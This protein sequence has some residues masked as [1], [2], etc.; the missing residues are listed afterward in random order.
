MG[1]GKIHFTLYN[2]F[3]YE[4]VILMK[5]I[6]RSGDNVYYRVELY[7]EIKEESQGGYMC[8]VMMM[9]SLAMKVPPTISDE[10]LLSLIAEKRTPEAIDL[11]TILADLGDIPKPEIYDKDSA[12]NICLYQ[13]HEF[14]EAVYDLYKIDEMLREITDDKYSLSYITFDAI[15]ED[16]I[17]YEDPYQIVI[18]RETYEEQKIPNYIDLEFALMIAEEREENYDDE[19]F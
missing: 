9:M 13:E 15:G 10:E 1:I 11:L 7:D 5:N 19:D 18:S 14:F 4:G 16:D 12:N 3:E 17:L 8:A 6:S 2:Y